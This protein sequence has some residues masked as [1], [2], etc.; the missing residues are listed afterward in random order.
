MDGFLCVRWF[1]LELNLGFSMTARVIDIRSSSVLVVDEEKS[2]KRVWNDP[3][4]VVN[5]TFDYLFF[6]GTLC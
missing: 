6:T 2:K 3:I 1:P 5:V 4:C